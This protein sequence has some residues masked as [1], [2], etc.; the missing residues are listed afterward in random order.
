MRHIL[1]FGCDGAALVATLD[2]APD[3]AGLLIIS[4]GNEIRIGAHRGMAKLAA[5]VAAAG[6][7]VFRFDRRGI[8]DSEGEN[9]GFEGSG[10]DIAA[11]IV[12]FREQCPALARI[13]AFGNCDAASAL[14]LHSLKGVD[15]L[16]LANPWVVASQDELPA[17]AAIRARY[18]ERIR[19]PKAWLD[20]IRGGVDFRKLLGGLRKIS[21]SASPSTLAGS[22]ADGI[23]SFDGPVSI[24]LAERDG[25]AIAFASEWRSQRFAQA[26]A[27]Q[28]ITMR[29]I[30]SASHS[31]ASESDY[32]A[33]KEVILSA[34]GKGN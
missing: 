2:S 14:A 7:P 5:D 15:S 18:I 12:A 1:S 8:G 20:L 26:R 27:R 28:G 3:T 22:V 31:F 6:H 33:L 4:G 32:A 25:T 16:V 21:R 19:D 30:D 23:E 13:V 9:T 10:P 17:P 11:A 34:L 29:S 24:L